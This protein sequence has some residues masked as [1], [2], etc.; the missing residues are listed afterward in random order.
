MKTLDLKEYGEVKEIKNFI[1]KVKGLSNCMNGQIVNFN[2]DTQGMVVGFDEEDVKVLI[3]KKKGDIKPGDRV[4]SRIET[5]KI[6]V[7]EKFLGR[8][9]N[10]LCEPQDGKGKITPDAQLAVFNKATAVLERSP[11]NEVLESGIKIIDS[12]IP[13]GKGQRELIVGDR[14]TGKTSL[15]TDI[16]LN[17]K[18][19]KVICIYCCIGKP[20]SSFVK[21]LSI[22]EVKRAFDYL[23]VVSATSSSSPGQQYLAPYA[24][25]AL[26]EYFMFKGRDV[27]VAFDD[28]SKHAWAWREISLLLNRSPGR[29]AYPGDVFY[30]H[31]QFME[32]ACKLSKEKGAGSM[33]FLPIADIIQGDVTG[34]IPSN[35]ISMTDGQVY[36]NTTLFKEGFKP[37]IDIGLS[38]SRIGNKIQWP[39]IRDLTRMLRL[40]YVKLKD[41]ER[42]TKIKLGVSDE[43]KSQLHKYNIFTELFK[44]DNNAPVS[45]EEQVVIFYALRK[46][47]LDPLSLK[48]VVN[49]KDEIFTFI[50][51]HDAGLTQDIIKEKE[52]SAHIC[53]GLDKILKDYLAGE[54]KKAASENV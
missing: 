14:M 50:Q 8:I 9:V 6:P 51:R 39:A 35:L 21:Q 10:A 36:L 54:K 46:G 37:A 34:Y 42:L 18:G 43:I 25:C 17:Q 23:V 15:V 29:E 32:R 2:Y 49:F 31:S 1:V 20:V 40:E 41:L 47:F 52:L 19:K 13:L 5:F 3:I 16:I 7:G 38:V 4:F 22:F 44:Q 26:G 28:L 48:E 27:L 24:A 30:L 12:M 45:M 53:E 11:I 33:T